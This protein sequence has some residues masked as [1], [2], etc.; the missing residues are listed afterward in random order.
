MKFQDKL[1]FVR[2][3]LNLSQA[4]LAKELNVSLPTV[5]RWENGKSNPTKKAKMVFI[6]FC[7]I[8]DIKFEGDNNE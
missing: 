5:S 1:V 7:E 6:Q 4:E 8:N 2:A 3:K